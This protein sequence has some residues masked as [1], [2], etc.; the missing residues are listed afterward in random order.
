MKKLLIATALASVLATPAA[1]F[2]ASG[3]FIIAG[4]HYLNRP[5][6]AKAGTIDVTSRAQDCGF[7]VNNRYSTDIDG[8]RPGLV[9]QTI[10]PYQSRA[11]VDRALSK[12]KRCVPD[13]FVKETTVRGQPFAGPSRRLNQEE[14]DA[15]EDDVTVPDEPHYV[16]SRG[17]TVYTESGPVRI[18]T[19]CELNA[20]NFVFRGKCSVGRLESDDSSYIAAGTY[21]FRIVRSDSDP[22]TGKFYQIDMRGEDYSQ[23]FIG[24]VEARGACWVGMGSGTLHFCAR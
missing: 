15:S 13:A 11:S 16:A 8:L 4:S 23:R 24:R 22:G 17:R 2:Q 18:G 1:A 5:V 19:S 14:I 10:G 6:S 9:V 20:N 3:Y 7:G 21:M 12:L